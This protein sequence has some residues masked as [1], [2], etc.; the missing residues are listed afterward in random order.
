MRFIGNFLEA[1]V[2]HAWYY[3]HGIHG[4]AAAFFLLRPALESPTLVLFDCEYPL[5][6]FHIFKK[7][8][9]YRWCVFEAF[10]DIHPCNWLVDDHYSAAEQSAE[11]P[12]VKEISIFLRIY[13]FFFEISAWI[14]PERVFVK[15]MDCTSLFEGLTS[16]LIFQPEIID[17]G[18]IASDH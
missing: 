15:W 4:K 16:K 3:T 8:W 14:R 2:T 11:L 18:L 12:W 5:V 10:I 9:S 13:T 7:H 1:K 6:T 17:I